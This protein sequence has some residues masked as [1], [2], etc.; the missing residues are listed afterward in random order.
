[1]NYNNLFPGLS[2]R[3][4]LWLATTYAMKRKNLTY[5]KLGALTGITHTYLVAVFKGRKKLTPR[6]VEQVKKHLDLD[7][8]IFL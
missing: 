5:R 7:L 2:P 1:M 8:S 3:S 6:V 4:A